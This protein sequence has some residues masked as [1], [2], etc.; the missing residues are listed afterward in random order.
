MY[1]MNNKSG[2]SS[3]GQ[4]HLQQRLTDVL[5]TPKNT[6]IMRRDYGCA[7]FDLVDKT[8]NESWLV[9][10]YAA[11]ADAIDLPV[12]GLPDFKLESIKPTEVTDAG[13]LFDLTGIY[14]PTGERV[15]VSVGGVV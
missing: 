4:L 6:R 10:C 12:N 3:E 9:Q 1:G 11:I 2:K 14:L 13:A 7:L 8:I 5:T 15:T